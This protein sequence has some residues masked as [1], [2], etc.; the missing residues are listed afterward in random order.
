MRGEQLLG[1]IPALAVLD[2]AAPTAASPVT[3]PDLWPDTVQVAVSYADLDLRSA[4][5]R[6]ALG[7]R[8]RD[9]AHRACWQVW[10]TPRLDDLSTCLNGALD[11]ARWQVRQ[12]ERAARS[13]GSAAAKASPDAADKRTETIQVVAH[14]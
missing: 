13:G 5:G 14:L 1:L 7:R 12:A 6:E 2:F 11:D 10:N 4:A 8:I 9:A 3:G